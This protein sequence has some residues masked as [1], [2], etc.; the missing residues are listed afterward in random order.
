M[1]IR[2]QDAKNWSCQVVL[3]HHA[4]DNGK[5]LDSSHEIEFGEIMTDKALV[6]D[7][8]RRAQRAILDPTTDKSYYL[9]DKMPDKPPQGKQPLSFSFNCVCVRVAG[10]GVPELYFYDLPGE[11]NH[12]RASRTY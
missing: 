12:Y 9:Q 10:P 3:R 1:E 11:T 7:R 5:P 4:Q 6:R 8:I 2:L